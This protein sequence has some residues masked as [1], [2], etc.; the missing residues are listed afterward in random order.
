MDWPEQQTPPEQ[1]A[2]A[3]TDT[4]V[5]LEPAKGRWKGA[6][7]KRLTRAAVVAVGILLGLLL[8]LA[9]AG[10]QP[11]ATYKE[12]AQREV[13]SFTDIPIPALE[14]EYPRTKRLTGTYRTTIPVLNF[15]QTIT[16]EGDTL[17]VV[18]EF[19]GTLVYR[20]IATM[21]SETEGILDL[22][23]IDSGR[24]SQVPMQYVPEADCLILYAQG[25]DKEGVTYCR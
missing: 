16:F 24:V 17:T 3:E 12:L 13:A 25:R 5:S 23:D 21:Q 7:L 6:R 19:A 9:Y 2:T 22:E 18:D 15:E 1:E 11:W 14:D 4:H 10:V 20:Y 8:A